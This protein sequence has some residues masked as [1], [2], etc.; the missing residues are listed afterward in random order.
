M[1]NALK[2]VLLFVATLA[3]LAAPARAME[4]ERSEKAGPLPKSGAFAVDPGNGGPGIKAIE[5]EAIVFVRRWIQA[6]VRMRLAER[7]LIDIAMQLADSQQSLTRAEAMLTSPDASQHEAVQTIIDQLHEWIPLQEHDLQVAQTT[8]KIR[9][10]S[11]GNFKAAAVMFFNIKAGSSLKA[12]N[13]K[14]V[15]EEIVRALPTRAQALRKAA[16]SAHKEFQDEEADLGNVVWQHA[17]AAVV[18]AIDDVV[19]T[20]K[21]Y[22]KRLDDKDMDE[23]DLR[24]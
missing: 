7:E 9:L 2:L 22:Q 16:S 8:Y 13:L 20:I 3:L 14:K 10:Q 18:V 17:G 21:D 19:K 24:L 6:E 12:I 15:A 1:K 4:K 11:V 5:K 23:V